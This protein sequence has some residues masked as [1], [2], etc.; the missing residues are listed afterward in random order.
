MRWIVIGAGGVGGVV[1]GL[2][3]RAGRDVVLV[4]RGEH[5]RRIREDGLR[6]ATPSFDE[7]I[8]VPVVGGPQELT[9]TRG[10]ALFLAVKSQDTKA[11]LEQWQTVE[12]HGGDGGG[13]VGWAGDLLP[14]LCAQNG[15]DNE[16]EALRRFATV[17]GVYVW[18]PGT[19]LEPG[20]VQ[21]Q[22]YPDPGVLGLGRYPAGAPS[23]D[24]LLTDLAADLGLAGF[25]A[26][27]VQDVMRWK[28]TKLLSNLGNA[29][30]AVFGPVVPGSEAEREADLATEEGRRVLDAAGIPTADPEELGRAQQGMGVRP[31]NGKP[32]SGGSTWQ[33]LVRG[34]GSVEV[35]QLN[36]EI[37]LL[38]RR[39]G[40]PTPVN[41]RLQLQVNAMARG[42]VRPGAGGQRL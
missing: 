8:T 6:L 3:A 17:I 10:D 24:R 12:V 42:G 4:A 9:A 30:E 20:T 13:V 7:R 18:L 31:V 2:L 40:I 26:P 21:C 39:L 35:D 14:V 22:G 41:A 36:G 15:I 34:T 33:S 19:Y 27:V 25:R 16:R 11:A 5:G 37:V 28:A 1:A 23:G 38:G 29:A 32:R